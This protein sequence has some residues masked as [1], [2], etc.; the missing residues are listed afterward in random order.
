MSI[1]FGS[2][3]PETTTYKA[4]SCLCVQYCDA[5]TKLDNEGIDNAEIRSELRKE[6][7][8]DCP[9]CSGSGIVDEPVFDG[10][11]LDLNHGNG[12]SLLAALGIPLESPAISLPEARRALMRARSRRSLAPFTREGCI[13][14][15]APRDRGDGVVDLHPIRYA[16]F[17]FGEDDLRAR[18]DRFASFVEAVAARGGTAISWSY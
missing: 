13:E 2:N 18:I 10:P 8:V 12:T 7:W 3:A 14:Y 1:T 11:M 5:I 4:A 16:D 17:A 15:G 9:R 6:A